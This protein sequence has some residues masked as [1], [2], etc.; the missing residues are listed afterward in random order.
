MLVPELVE[1]EKKIPPIFPSFISTF[2]GVEKE[3]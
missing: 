3:N 2:K 1:G